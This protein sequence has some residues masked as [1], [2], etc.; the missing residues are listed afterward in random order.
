MHEII[1][2]IFRV[3]AVTRNTDFFLFRVV[4]AAYAC[5]IHAPDSKENNHVFLSDNNGGHVICIR[6]VTK[7]NG[8]T[9]HCFS[10]G[11]DNNGGHMT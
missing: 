2:S 11:P 8:M 4:I 1:L 10:P 7:D 5:C 9:S 3:A 6:D